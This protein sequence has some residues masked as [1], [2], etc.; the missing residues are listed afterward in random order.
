MSYWKSLPA[1]ITIFCSNHYLGLFGLSILLL[2][3]LT[4][5]KVFPILIDPVIVKAKTADEVTAY[6]YRHTT[7]FHE[8]ITTE[9]KARLIVFDYEGKQYTIVG[10]LDEEERE[11]IDTKVIFNK[12]APEKAA[13]YTFIGLMDFPV[14]KILFTAW[15]LLTAILYA[16]AISDKHF[17][18]FNFDVYNLTSRQAIAIA[19]ILLLIPFI[20]HGRT[21]ILGK[22]INGLITDEVIFDADRNMHRAIVYQ[23]DGIEY[24]FGAEGKFND[25][26][27]MIGRII[28]IRFD[29]TK[30]QN[31]CICDLII[32]Y[33]NYW[34]ILTGIGL[35]FLAG[36]FYATRPKSNDKQ[37]ESVET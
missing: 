34:V 22:T 29:V 24:K 18:L 14:L 33:D 32:I 4:F 35:I 36:W 17:S 37:N 3:V 15:V 30:P 27:Y 31:A 20:K 8:R 28:P 1:R 25:E 12:S 13:E 23:V 10:G 16:T 5:H 26:N 6:R 7:R 19:V 2:A 21:L 11:G 9:V